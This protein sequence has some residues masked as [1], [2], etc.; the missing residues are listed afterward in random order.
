[1][2]RCPRQARRRGRKCVGGRA[3]EKK[4]PTACRVRNSFG[5]L[6]DDVA[7]FP[8]SRLSSAVG[9]TT[10]EPLDPARA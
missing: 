3:D 8:N 10:L 6:P 7:I 1:M 4:V 5:I 9:S 2:C